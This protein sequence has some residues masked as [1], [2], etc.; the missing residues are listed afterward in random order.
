M[1]E[2]QT[3]AVS[4]LQQA[5][6]AVLEVAH[7]LRDIVVD[8]V[9]VDHASAMRE[10]LRVQTSRRGW[11]LTN[12]RCLREP[13]ITN[14]LLAIVG[15]TML[16]VLIDNPTDQPILALLRRY[17]HRIKKRTGEVGELPA[18]RGASLR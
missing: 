17:V 4:S 5:M 3:I 15:G 2:I 1:A 7:I 18:A 8:T 9:R 6:R 10:L 14:G 11:G 12:T 13:S 16:S